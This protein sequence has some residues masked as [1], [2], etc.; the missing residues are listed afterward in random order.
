MAENKLVKKAGF[1]LYRGFKIYRHSIVS[2]WKI[3]PFFKK[4]Q[5]PS[6]LK[7]AQNIIDRHLT[8]TRKV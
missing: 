4:D 2:A 7:I 5:I 6:T 1:Y 3:E 8:N